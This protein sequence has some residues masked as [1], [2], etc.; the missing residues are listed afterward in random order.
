[1]P[2]VM[3]VEVEYGLAAR[4]NGH[5]LDPEEAGRRLF[6]PLARTH[7]STSAFLPN[8]GRLYLDVGAHPEYATPECADARS[9]VVAQRAGDELM[10]DLADQARLADAEQHRD[11]T[12]SLTRNNRDAAGHAWGFHTNHLVPRTVDPHLLTAWLVPFLVSRGVMSGA[13]RWHRGDFRLTQR[14]EVYAEAVSR[15]TTR[16]RP[17][18]NT[19]DEPHAD[20]TRFRRLHLLAGDTLTLEMPLWLTLAT[21]D[22]VIRAAVTGSRPPAGPQDPVKALRIWDADPSAPVAIED[23]TQSSAFD[24]Q[25]RWREAVGEWATAPDARDALSHWGALLTDVAAGRPSCA[26]WDVKRRTLLAWQRRHAAAPDDV[27]LEALDLAWHDIGRRA[28][29]RPTGIARLVE[30]RGQAVRLTTDA[31]VEAASRESLSPTRAVARGRLVATAHTY[32][33]DVTVDW[34][35]VTVNDFPGGSV[36]LEMPDPSRADVAG[37]DEMLVRMASVPRIGPLRGFVPPP[38]R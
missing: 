23:G 1:M 6:V 25:H 5:R 11:T 2:A 24:V 13:G 16:A 22:L 32:D 7:G 29:G 18:I 19:R 10:L 14:A 38:S 15:N 36:R 20:P 12:F 27:R 31:E 33:R 3:G 37:V 17:L 26:E 35:H 9:A 4:S 34:E 8:G 30:S 21:T 28:D